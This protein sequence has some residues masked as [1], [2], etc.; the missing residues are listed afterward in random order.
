[1]TRKLLN[2]NQKKENRIKSYLKYLKTDKGKTARNRALKNYYAKNK[3][4][5]I[6]RNKKYYT[7]TYSKVVGKKKGTGKKKGANI[8]HINN[9]EIK[10]NKIWKEKI[11]TKDNTYL[12]KDGDT[13]KT[14]KL[15]MEEFKIMKL[16]HN[17]LN[18]IL[19]FN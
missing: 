11:I 9:K 10:L 16:T 1:M 2:E 13:D 14:Y 3:Q 18:I 12:I 19:N 5:I 7:D 6:D 15:T 8:K 17:N 4:S